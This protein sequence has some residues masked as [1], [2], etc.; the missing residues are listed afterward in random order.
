MEK[1]QRISAN[2]YGVSESFCF[3]LQKEMLCSSIVIPRDIIVSKREQLSS[4]LKQVY[5]ATKEI[6]F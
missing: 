5:S 4:D 1:S 3:V 2:L 6:I